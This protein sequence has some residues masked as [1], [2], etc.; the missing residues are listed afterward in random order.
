MLNSPAPAPCRDQDHARRKPDERLE[1]AAIQWQ[2]L[3]KLLVDHR[4]DGR[5]DVHLLP[6]SCKGDGL[7][8]GSDLHG[9]VAAYRVLRAEGQADENDL[10]KSVIVD[11]QPVLPGAKIAENIHCHPGWSAAVEL[12]PE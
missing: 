9:E 11:G 8:D 5:R 6:R 3:H 10:L 2:V 7:D 4:A 12:V 1:A